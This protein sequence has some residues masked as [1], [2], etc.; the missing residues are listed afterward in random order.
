MHNECLQ[1]SLLLYKRE[2]QQQQTRWA[3]A[4]EL[5][6]SRRVQA[7]GREPVPMEQASVPDSPD[8]DQQPILQNWA[9]PRLFPQPLSRS[10]PRS[11]EE[12]H[13]HGQQGSGET[14]V[15]RAKKESRK[16]MYGNPGQRR[17]QT[18]KFIPTGSSG[19]AEQDGRWVKADTTPAG[20][21]GR[22]MEGQERGVSR[23]GFHWTSTPAGMTPKR[24]LPMQTACWRGSLRQVLP[25]QEWWSSTRSPVSWR[26]LLQHPESSKS[27]HAPGLRG[28]NRP[29]NPDLLWPDS[30]VCTGA[31]PTPEQ[32]T[33]KRGMSDPCAPDASTG[34]APHTQPLFQPWIGNSP[35]NRD[36]LWT[37]GSAYPPLTKRVH[38]LL[39]LCPLLPAWLWAYQGTGVS[40]KQSQC[41]FLEVKTVDTSTSALSSSWKSNGSLGVSPRACGRSLTWALETKA[42]SQGVT[43]IS[44]VQRPRRKFRE[45]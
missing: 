45:M 14:C 37:R 16:E 13:P 25:H 20:L 44:M 5:T 40:A 7:P 4:A 8:T 11:R 28:Q 10:S 1:S 17:V 12:R 18:M 30:V 34:H 29:D 36:A 32:L 42:N 31:N 15:V 43:V 38:Q 6:E 3:V 23:A 2:A 22:S 27:K 21:T 41:L 24:G 39:I 35:A 33:P 19:E 26:P 9:F